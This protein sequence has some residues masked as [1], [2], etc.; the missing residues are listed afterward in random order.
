MTDNFMMITATAAKMIVIAYNGHYADDDNDVDDDDDVDDDHDD[1]DDDDYDDSIS[2]TKSHGALSCESNENKSKR[3]DGK[4]TVI[5]ANDELITE[6]RAAF[7]FGGG[8]GGGV[9]R[10]LPGTKH[11]TCC[12]KAHQA[13]Q[14]GNREHHSVIVRR[15]TRLFMT[16]LFSMKEL[17]DALK[18][19]KTRKAP[20]PD[21]ITGE[22]LKHLGACSRSVLL[23]I[24]N[25]SWMQ[26]GNRLLLYQFQRKAKTR[27]TL[28]AIAPSVF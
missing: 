3:E 1:D 2:F 24:F 14:R 9:C 16:D 12:P 10:P 27:R 28:A 8:G 26:S 18:K 13:G 5:E 23:Q 4:K 17:K 19:V 11:H 6:K 15:R 22:M 21:G 25:H 7:F 20:G